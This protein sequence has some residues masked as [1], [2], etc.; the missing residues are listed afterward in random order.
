M[1]DYGDGVVA[2]R[3]C[4]ILAASAYPATVGI[5]IM[6]SSYVDIDADVEGFGTSILVTGND[7]AASGNVRITGT[8][9]NYLTAGIR[10]RS[11]YRYLHLQFR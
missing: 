6:Q 1:Y 9:R 10:A 4:S 11:C 2:I 8:S 5:K 7:T 3:G